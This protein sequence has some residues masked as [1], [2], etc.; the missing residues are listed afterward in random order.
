EVGHPAHDFEPARILL[1]EDDDALRMML[2]RDLA[3]CG[4]DVVGARSLHEALAFAASAEHLDV[5]VAHVRIPGGD[6]RQL[7]AIVTERFP[8]ARVL[9]ASRYSR[10]ELD[11]H[12][13]DLGVGKLIP[14]PFH[15]Q[16]VLAALERAPRDRGYKR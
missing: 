2:Q 14:R 10:A 3:A 11:T 4:H 8:E 12:G 16:D 13:V 1:V 9:F 7:S 5:L 6:A 15:L